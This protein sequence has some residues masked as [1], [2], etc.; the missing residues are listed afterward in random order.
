MKLP[1]AYLKYT[2]LMTEPPPRDSHTPRKHSQQSALAD[3]LATDFG[4]P[5]SFPPLFGGNAL[6][7]ESLPN[8][9]RMPPTALPRCTSHNCGDKVRHLPNF[10]RPA[11]QASGR[12]HPRTGPRAREQSLALSQSRPA[13]P[14][15]WK[16]ERGPTR[17]QVAQKC[18]RVCPLGSPSHF[19]S[20]SCRPCA[21]SLG[22]DGE[23]IKMARGRGQGQTDERTCRGLTNMFF[24]ACLVQCHGGRQE[25]LAVCVRAC[26]L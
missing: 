7:V 26:A 21:S 14:S 9:R 20:P 12:L 17:Y 19:M 11:S 2:L 15:P 4:A 24:S 22:S 18:F 6:G 23:G 16:P 25:F 13:I 8:A 3:A 10:V 1:R 5:F